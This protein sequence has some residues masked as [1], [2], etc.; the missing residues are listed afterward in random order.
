[1]KQI[2]YTKYINKLIKTIN[3]SQT[4]NNAVLKQHKNKLFRIKEVL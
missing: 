3:Q 2:P 1:M 4:R